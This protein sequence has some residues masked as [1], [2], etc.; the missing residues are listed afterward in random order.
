MTVTL[1]CCILGASVIM[2]INY[3][4][5]QNKKTKSQNASISYQLDGYGQVI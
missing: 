4:S 5:I 1:L 3:T 2:Y